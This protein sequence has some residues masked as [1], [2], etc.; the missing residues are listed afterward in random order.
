M[1]RF[2]GSRKKITADDIRERKN[3]TSESRNSMVV[4]FC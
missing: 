4:N 1:Q 3:V 2:R